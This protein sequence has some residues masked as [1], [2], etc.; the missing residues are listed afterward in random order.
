MVP[1]TYTSTMPDLLLVRVIHRTPEV[2]KDSCA[3]PDEL[4]VRTEPPES[5]LDLV[6][7]QVP[8]YLILDDVFSYVP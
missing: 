3:Y 1:S 6:V 4:R 7:F 8:L 2:V 5:R